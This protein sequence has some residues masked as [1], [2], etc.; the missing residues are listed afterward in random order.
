ME[1]RQKLIDKVK[2]I[3]AKARNNPNTNEAESAMLLAQRLQL[4]YKIADNELHDCDVELVTGNAETTVRRQHPSWMWQLAQVIADNFRCHVY[5][6]EQSRFFNEKADK[7]FKFF[8]EQDDSEVA[9]VVFELA[10]DTAKLKWSEYKKEHRKQI[11]RRKYPNRARIEFLTGFVHGVQ[12][13][14]YHQVQ[15]YGLILVKHKQV[16]QQ[17]KVMQENFSS[18]HT[19][20]NVPI[21]STN[22]YGQGRVDGRNFL[23]LD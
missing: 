9:K 17:Y 5:Q 13:R 23:S 14:F 16:E 18:V 3:L 12:L 11:A 10:V 2:K 22:A 15:E 19:K 21:R 6:S 4:T 1:Q 8:G 20:S 7:C